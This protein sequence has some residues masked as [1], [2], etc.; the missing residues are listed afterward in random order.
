MKTKYRGRSR[1]AIAALVGATTVL[2]IASFGGAAS[3]EACENGTPMRF[4]TEDETGF[5]ANQVCLQGEWV[6]ISRWQIKPDELVINEPRDT[7][8]HLTAEAFF[9]LK[10]YDPYAIIT[11]FRDVVERG[12]KL[13]ETDMTELLLKSARA[14]AQALLARSTRLNPSQNCQNRSQP[15]SDWNGPEPFPLV[16]GGPRVITYALDPSL[17][18]A[19]T[20]VILNTIAQYRPTVDAQDY[21]GNYPEDIVPDDP[22]DPRPPT[23][24]FRSGTE[25][26]LAAD[27]EGEYKN[28]LVLGETDPKHVRIEIGLKPTLISAEVTLIDQPDELHPG[29]VA[30]EIGHVLGIRH[31]PRDRN[32]TM[33]PSVLPVNTISPWDVRNSHND[34]PA[35]D[36]C[37]FLPPE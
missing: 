24:I 36:A 28:R 23:I 29:V 21:A 5:V 2:S 14:D 37:M 6:S 22:A 8:Y 15:D 3:A 19:Q 18:T 17:S 30:H 13:T 9:D 35:F 1:K 32:A 25:A 16:A 10:N 33:R 11:A 4:L 7:K 34:T 27:Y 26:E 20:V 12:K 31:T